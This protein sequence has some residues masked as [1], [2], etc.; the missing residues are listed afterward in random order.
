M[1]R[2]FKTNRT[3]SYSLGGAVQGALSG[4]AAGSAVL[5]GWGTA[6][7]AGLGMIPGLFDGKNKAL[8]EEEL[9]RKKLINETKQQNEDNRYTSDVNQLGNYSQS[10]GTASYYANGGPINGTDLK[11][12]ANTKRIGTGIEVDT[13]KKGTDKID[14]TIGGKNIKLD[15]DEIIVKD[16]NGQYVV[17]S[18]DNGEATSYRKEVEAGGNPNKIGL[19]YAERAK[20]I[21][22]NAGNE[23]ASGGE[24]GNPPYKYNN[25]G[26]AWSNKYRAGDNMTPMTP[27]NLNV[28]T[29][30]PNTLINSNINGSVN[31]NNMTPM[32]LNSPNI[33]TSTP[34][35]PNTLASRA[36]PNSDIAKTGNSPSKFNAIG[37]IQPVGN[38]ALGVI[39]TFEN[40][41]IKDRLNAM[42]Y[43]EYEPI[44]A[45]TMDTG[46]NK[47]LFNKARSDVKSGFANV[48][49]QIERNTTSS[50]VTT[51]RL[52][53]LKAGEL[54]NLGDITAK[55][56]ADVNRIGNAN[57]NTTNR[58][59]AMNAQGVNQNRVGQYQDSL[60]KL[61][62][63]AAFN[64]SSI[65]TAQGFLDNLGKANYQGAQ[66][67]AL[68]EAY[69]LSPRLD[70]ENDQDYNNR[71]MKKAYTSAASSF[72]K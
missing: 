26:D 50:P 2:N 35:T 61:G 71:L 17:I 10:S 33:P 49:K 32:T 52:A 30:A 67:D 72:G 39:N 60:N 7:G 20:S 69:N 70:G 41:G 28:P 8:E 16:A 14:A 38:L 53:A 54:S 13:K 12:N 6:I 45:N 37:L 68:A 36:T 66:L 42:E 46:V 21:N 22:P 1:R 24:F 65:G 3:N 56:T 11:I 18:D 40:K 64:Q 62:T 29:N 15:D 23:L 58:V 44:R 57:I 31:P 4:A 34:S 27:L 55:E 63:E 51:S 47:P 5:P 43:P 25:W 9:R 59:A 19:K 48:G